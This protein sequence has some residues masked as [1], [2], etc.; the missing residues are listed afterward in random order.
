MRAPRN[1]EY[2]F[3]A[4]AQM[5]PMKA[6]T[7]EKRRPGRMPYFR[8]PAAMNAPMAPVIKRQ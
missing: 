8:V 2:D 4:A 3:A 1:E 5:T 7:M 6:Q